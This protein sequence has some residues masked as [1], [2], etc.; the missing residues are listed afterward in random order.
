MRLY[1]ERDNLKML[2][3]YITLQISLME[4]ANSLMNFMCGWFVVYV[5]V[6]S[7]SSRKKNE[8]N[9]KN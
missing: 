8:Q 5:S 2:W 6:T 1:E 4:F 9:D 7:Q 3:P